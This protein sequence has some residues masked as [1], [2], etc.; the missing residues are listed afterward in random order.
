M[1]CLGSRRALR[2]AAQH[3]RARSP[4]ALEQGQLPVQVLL[5]V[6][7]SLQQDVLELKCLGR[8]SEQVVP[9]APVVAVTPVVLLPPLP[10]AKD[11]P[12]ENGLE[13]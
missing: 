11:G 13:A 2:P 12:V 9:G 1:G 10:A 6:R 4:N 5:V 7:P 8:F 3:V